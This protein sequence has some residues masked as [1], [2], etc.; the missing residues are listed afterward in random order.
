MTGP[1]TIVCP[2]VNIK[3]QLQP[4]GQTI[5]AITQLRECSGH[6]GRKHQVALGIDSL[7]LTPAADNLTTVQH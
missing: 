7:A 2:G 3:C 4:V 5:L 6:L 1:F